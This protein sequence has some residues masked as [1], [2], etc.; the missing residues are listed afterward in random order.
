MNRSDEAQLKQIFREQK[1][2]D[3]HLKNTKIAAQMYRDALAQEMKAE[4][5]HE[6]FLLLVAFAKDEWGQDTVVDDFTNPPKIVIS[7]GKKTEEI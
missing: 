2:A 6:L 3:L 4:M 5:I 7:N 1:Q